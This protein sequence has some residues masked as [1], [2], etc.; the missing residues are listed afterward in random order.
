MTVVELHMA[1][2]VFIYLFLFFKNTES[3][4][5]HLLTHLHRHRHGI[6]TREL[7]TLVLPASA[8]VVVLMHIPDPRLQ[9]TAEG[10]VLLTATAPQHTIPART[11]TTDHK[12]GVATVEETRK[13]IT[14]THHLHLTMRRL[15][16]LVRLLREMP[17]GKMRQHLDSTGTPPVRVVVAAVAVTVEHMRRREP[18]RRLQPLSHRLLL[19]MMTMSL[20]IIKLWIQGLVNC[21]H[22]SSIGIMIGVVCYLAVI[23]S[24]SFSCRNGP[25]NDAIVVRFVRRSD[26]I[27]R[28]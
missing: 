16:A 19:E 7:R 3:T 27:S 25:K 28:S 5:Q 20:G 10:V 12:L 24:T 21:C 26:Q 17:T 8:V 18:C 15:L 14:A 11:P 4:I 13:T 1:E 22:S 23:L 6:L 9:H 2:Y